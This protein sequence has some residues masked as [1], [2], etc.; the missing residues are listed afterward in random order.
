MPPKKKIPKSKIQ[1][2]DT[3]ALWDS[4]NNQQ[5]GTNTFGH[6]IKITKHVNVQYQK[7]Y[8]VKWVDIDNALSYGEDNLNVIL[9]P[10][11]LLKEIV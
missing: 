8:W 4:T 9:D 11:N 6:V 7:L 2:G 1:V 3:V 10:N 5:I